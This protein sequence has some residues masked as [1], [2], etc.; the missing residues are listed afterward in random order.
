MIEN[1]KDKGFLVA[2]RIDFIIETIKQV[3]NKGELGI[4]KINVGKTIKTLFY[5]EIP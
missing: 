4:T 3:F 2:L 5:D 1:Y